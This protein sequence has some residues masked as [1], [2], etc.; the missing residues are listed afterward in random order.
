M[1]TKNENTQKRWDTTSALTIWMDAFASLK[2]LEK[3]IGMPEAGDLPNYLAIL[4][5]LHATG[6]KLAQT[7]A[8]KD[9]DLQKKAKSHLFT[10]RSC[11]EELQLVYSHPLNVVKSGQFLRETARLLK[12]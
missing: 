3:R 8:A 4:T 12:V 10:L 2:N 7:M 11:L 6:F 1:I 9:T 5:E